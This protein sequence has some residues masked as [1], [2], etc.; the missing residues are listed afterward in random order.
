MCEGQKNARHE[1]H[2]PGVPQ[3]ILNS[4]YVLMHHV[5]ER[6]MMGMEEGGVVT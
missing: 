6:G 2:I 3:L 4:K 1:V 5:S